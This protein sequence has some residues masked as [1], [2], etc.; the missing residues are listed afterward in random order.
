MFSIF[1]FNKVLLMYSSTFNAIAFTKKKSFFLQ[2]IKHGIQYSN[3][4]SDVQIRGML[5]LKY[6]N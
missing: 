3:P 5:H 2:I 1:G 4:Q 6:K